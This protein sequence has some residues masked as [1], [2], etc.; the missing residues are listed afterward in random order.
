[1]PNDTVIDKDAR[2]REVRKVTLIGS[3]LDLSLAVAKIIVG[4]IGQSQ[5][6]IADGIHSMSDLLT[7]FM[8]LFAFKHSN[9]EADEDHPYGHG[10]IE[11]LM[12]VALGLALILI[13]VGI[14]WDAIN[15]LFE[16]DLLLHPSWIVLV[17]AAIS[18]IS[19]EAIYHYTM[20][21]ARKYKSALLRANA[22]HSRTDAISSIIVFVGVLGSMAG[23]DYLDAIAAIGVALMIIKIGWDLGWHSVR[24]LIDTGLEI[25][26]VERIRKIIT[27]VEGVR[28]MHMLRTRKMGADA[29]VD[30]HIQ[31][32]SMLSVSEG[33]QISEIVRQQLVRNI[34]DVSDV[35]VHIDPEDDEFAAISCQLPSRKQIMARLQEAWRDIEAAKQIQSVTLHYLDGFIHIDAKLPLSLAC[36]D[37]TEKLIADLKESAVALKEVQEIKIGFYTD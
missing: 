3:A 23:L 17:V 12:T 15:R 28:S 30:V 10:R 36:V 13:G 22:W 18:I 16:P 29:F 32:D 37:T 11:T 27:E 2:Y 24:E 35:T 19:K 6:L 26:E 21:A 1:M 5:A 33:H 25:E 7:D 9:R 34:E 31:V 8:V 20:T 4:Y 14:A